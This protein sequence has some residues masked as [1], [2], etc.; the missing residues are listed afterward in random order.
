MILVDALIEFE[1]D[2]TSFVLWGDC[3][4][5]HVTDDAIDDQVDLE[6]TSAQF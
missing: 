1:K 2:L 5:V 3:R 6:L 4:N